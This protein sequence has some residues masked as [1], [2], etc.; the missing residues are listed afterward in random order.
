[1]TTTEAVKEEVK[2]VRVR[3]P[4]VEDLRRYTKEELQ[5]LSIPELLALNEEVLEL[6]TRTKEE[7]A[8]R[9]NALGAK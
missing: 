3:H 4:N 6:M 7:K 1:M 8:D 9:M 5:K 2:R